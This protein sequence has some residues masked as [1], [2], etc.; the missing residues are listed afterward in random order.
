MIKSYIGQDIY[1][2]WA[3][4][5]Y[6]VSGERKAKVEHAYKSENGYILT[7]GERRVKCGEKL[8]EVGTLPLACKALLFDDTNENSIYSRS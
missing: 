4:D 6:D 5:C 8:D 1:V 7:C 2:G 3:S